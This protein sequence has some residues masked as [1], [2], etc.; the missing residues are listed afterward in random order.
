M[1][2]FSR[3]IIGTSFLCI[4]YFLDKFGCF[5]S[6]LEI[7]GILSVFCVYNGPT[8]MRTIHLNNVFLY[9]I[10]AVLGTFLIVLIARLIERF[11]LLSK[12]VKIWGEGS[13]FI[14]CTHTIFMIIQ[15]SSIFC[16]KLFGIGFV[17]DFTTTAIVMFFE[18]LMYSM[19]IK[20]SDKYRFPYFHSQAGKR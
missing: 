5:D 12:I 10:F 1:L 3:I 19:F 16:F 15:I 17:A 9:F 20:L 8:D 2:L 7:L 14:M 6:K 13:L 4:G 11:F 18:T